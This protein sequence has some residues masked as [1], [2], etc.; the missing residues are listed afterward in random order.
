M[1]DDQ[2]NYYGMY[3]EA[4]DL[5]IFVANKS[6]AMNTPVN[7]QKLQHILWDIEGAY[8]EEYGKR[9]LR[10]QWRSSILGPMLAGVRLML[11]LWGASPITHPIEKGDYIP[12]TREVRDI[13]TQ[14]IEYWRD[15]K[16]WDMRNVFRDALPTWHFNTT[17]DE[18]CHSIPYPLRP[19]AK[20]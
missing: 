9:Y 11:G 1:S 6:L 15:E 17:T 13:A 8:F 4:R 12:P 5:A 2:R 18:P 14:V 16:V 7:P 19:V 20:L 3:K 10:E